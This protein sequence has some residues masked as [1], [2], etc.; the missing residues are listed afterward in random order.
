MKLP[1]LTFGGGAG[2]AL[3]TGRFSG[4]IVTMIISGSDM[5]STYFIPRAA[6]DSSLREQVG[7][8]ASLQRR[9]NQVS[10]IPEGQLWVGFLCSVTF[11]LPL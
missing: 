10:H 6:R 3:G 11:R 8:Q 2:P 9:E 7:R 5:A 1:S 4:L